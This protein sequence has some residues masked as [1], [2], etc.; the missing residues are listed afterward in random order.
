MARLQDFPVVIRRIGWRE[1]LRRVWRELGDDHLFTFAAALAYAWLFAI[2][3]FIIFT[4]NVVTY[5]PVGN[6]KATQEG[7]HFFLQKSL[8]NL[9]ADTLRDTVDNTLDKIRENRSGG[10]LSVSLLVALWA[11]SGG[12]NVTMYVLEKCYELDKGQAFRAFHTRR[13][14]AIG[15]TAMV[16][17]LLLLVVLL[18]PVGATFKGWLLEN[19]AG[20]VS[21]W[22]LFVYDTVRVCLAVAVALLILGVIYHFG[23]GVKHYWHLVTP[24]AVFTLTVWVLVGFAFRYYVNHFGASSYRE[25][26]G[27]VGA[28]AILLLLFYIDAVVLL[29]GAEINSEIDFELLQV[30]RGTRNFRIAER[31]VASVEPR[32]RPAPARAAATFDEGSD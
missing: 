2:F 10:V 23:P 28:V 30:P 13:P 1:F 16:S 14:M 8:P 11:A 12:V 26:Y 17:A 4:L 27:T 24:G 32:P 9:A 5:L 3:P 6:Q 22:A 18:L 25:T 21:T 29:I 19:R 7:I 20:Q 31:R 15:L